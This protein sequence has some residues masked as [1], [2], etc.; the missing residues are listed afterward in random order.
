MKKENWQED[1]PVLKDDLERSQDTKEDAIRERLSDIFPQGV[2]EDS[3]LSGETQEFVIAQGP[4]PGLFVTVNT[5]VGY[6]PI[7]ERVI[8]ST[9]TGYTAAAPTTTTDNG[10]GGTT[11]TPQST[12][13]QNIP[14]TNAATNR[15]WLGYLKTTD[16]AVFT[17]KRLTN[18]R[19][20]VKSDDGYEIS[21]TTTDTNPDTTRFI[22]IGEV[23]A[24]A[25]AVTSIDITNIRQAQTTHSDTVPTSPSALEVTLPTIPISIP[26]VVRDPGG[27]PIALTFVQGTP[28]TGQFAVN[29]DTGVLTFAIDSETEAV[30]IDFDSLLLRREISKTLE[31]AA[32]VPVV[33]KPS[34]YEAGMPATYVEH[35]SARGGGII[36]PANPHGLSAADI[37]LADVQNIGAQLSSPGIILASGNGISTTSALSPRA[38]SSVILVDNKVSFSPLV[39]EEAVNIEGIIVTS[40]DIPA[41]VEFDFIDSGTGLG[42]A[43]GT[44]NFYIDPADK[45]IKRILGVVPTG[46]FS[47]AT[48]AW[49]GTQLQAPLVDLR[50]FGTTDVVNMRFEAM[51]ALSMNLASGNKASVYYHA[52]L[53]GTVAGTGADPA[54]N[55]GGDDIDILVDGTPGTITFPGAASS[56]LTIAGAGG[57]LDTITGSIGAIKALVTIG[58]EVKILA[59]ISL[60]ITGGTALAALGFTS[61]PPANEDSDGNL[62]V[63]LLSGD[64]SSTGINNAPK[65]VEVNFTYDAT[66]ETKLTQVSAIVGNRLLQTDLT[67]SADDSIATITESVT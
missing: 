60:E 20:F 66:P 36:A 55:V 1:Q 50:L 47:L 51:G 22:K 58:N 8:I 37:G 19:L 15:I 11:L 67:Y 39:S 64:A 27:T 54:F 30:D 13:S 41:I 26:S 62:K 23:V 65:D 17:L 3:Q 40:T 14:I 12:G 18:E 28:S 32:Q 49:T 31:V 53:T 57:I 7:G 46:S 4:S 44:Y 9:I 52:R 6:S 63:V 61:V 5:G 35:I 10:I 43:A 16:S 2:I 33:E 42:I 25:G 59:P 29:F 48:I 56:S 45:T 24:A 38:V 34:V 21:V